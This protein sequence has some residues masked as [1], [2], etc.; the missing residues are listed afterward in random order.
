LVAVVVVVLMRVWSLTRSD[1]ISLPSAQDVKVRQ[2]GARDHCGRE[3]TEA[4]L[5]LV[6]SQRA[7]RRALSRFRRPLRS[8]CGDD[9]CSLD[10]QGAVVTLLTRR[11]LLVMLS[12][13][14][15]PHLLRSAVNDASEARELLL[16]PL[17]LLPLL[18]LPLLLVPLLL[19]PLL[20][21][22]LL[23]LLMKSAHC[24]CISSLRLL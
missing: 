12:L 16:L 5:G 6:I 20:L 18:L 8:A 15:S 1:A 19:L 2:T 3:S 10:V 17:L 21:V 9:R 14:S 23:L 7:Q 22:P 24:C 13:L 11:L 4:A